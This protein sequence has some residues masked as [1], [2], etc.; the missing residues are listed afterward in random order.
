M[1]KLTK[2][3][4]IKPETYS[5]LESLAKEK[6]CTVTAALEYTIESANRTAHNSLAE[7]IISEMEKRFYNWQ[8]GVLLS[9]RQAERYGYV[10]IEMLNS[11]IQ[12]T[13]PSEEELY[14]S[15]HR[16]DELRAKLNGDKDAQDKYHLQ[17][18]KTYQC[19]TQ[20]SE[21]YFAYLKQRKSNN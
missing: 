9:S 13:I 3:F 2:T 14:M 19:A 8:T 20:E 17:S 16:F 10:L 11:L 15:T 5:I 1:N 18:S 12:N 4:R 7:E 21:D 6:H